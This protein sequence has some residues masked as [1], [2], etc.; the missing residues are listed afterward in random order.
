MERAL[1]Q[2]LKRAFGLVASYPCS[3]AW[4]AVLC[5]RLRGTLY[6]RCFFL[7]IS[8]HFEG[9]SCEAASGGARG[10]LH[11]DAVTVQRASRLSL[12][13]KKDSLVWGEPTYRLDFHHTVC[14][15]GIK[16]DS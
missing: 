15:K 16:T 4:E 14:T 5:K 7:T 10:T 13:N 8:G 1:F 6:L 2:S 12:D 11:S 9:F 3:I